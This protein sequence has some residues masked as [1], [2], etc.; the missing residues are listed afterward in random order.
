[1]KKT[2]LLSAL[3][4]V[5]LGVSTSSVAVEEM[6]WYFAPNLSYVIA[7]DDRVA[8]DDFGLQL[9]V[10]QIINQSWNIELSVVMDTLESESGASEF[11]QRGL[12]FDGLYFF[13][14]DRNLDP[15]LVAGIGGLQ[16]KF[17][18]DKSTNMMA[19]VGAGVM[20]MINDSVSLRADARYRLDD[21]DTSMATENRFGDWVVNI[22][23]A[24]P[25]GG[26]KAAPVAAP[27]VAA[28]MSE[29]VVMDSD[30]DGVSDSN[31][32]CAS[33]DSGAKVDANG[34]EMDSDKD[35]V[36]DRLDRCAA[37]PAGAKVD[38][39]GCELDSDMDGVVDRLDLC[40]GSAAGMKVDAKGCEQDSDRD[41]IL[42]SADSCPGSV[43]G[44]KVD[45]KGCE[46]AEVVV[47]QGVNFNS[48]STDLTD[49]AKVI[50]DKVAQTLKKNA[51]L[52][53]E[54]AGYTDNTGSKALNVSL[55]Q[56]RA[57]SVVNFLISRGV[58]GDK[59]IAKGYGPD[60]PI[61]DN[62]TAEGRSV[63]RRVEMH[64]VK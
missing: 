14:R 8:D 58:N 17:G 38:A 41:G 49:S 45:M 54:L 1:M 28:V 51:N 48:G 12:Q 7:D 43:V 32:R 10:G 13:D 35:G 46:I 63:N 34:C 44:A 37:T 11:K 47:L 31:D 33:T 42:D 60:S 59:L 19:N 30:D 5:T 24:I 39:K 29:P 56:R 21:D 9:G 25:F 6:Q 4:A 50:L 15:Y 22:G 20:H 36:I 61:A 23:L 2:Y 27:V 57:E 16:T 64:I 55:S 62:S 52:M 53:V 3:S 40:P 26:S 18:N